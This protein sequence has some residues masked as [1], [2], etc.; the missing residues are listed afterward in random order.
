FLIII[1]FLI[2]F[3]SI[4]QIYQEVMSGKENLEQTINSIQIQNFNQAKIFAQNSSNNFSAAIN[5]VEKLKSCLL[6]R[7]SSYLKNQINDI[8]YVL[9]A[10][11]SLSRA[12]GQSASF[13]QSLKDVINNEEKSIFSKLSQQEKQ[14]ILKYLYQSGPEL[15]G[16]KANVNLALI[17]L[18][19]TNL[20]NLLYP[21]KDR[22]N[23]L[24]FQLAQAELLLDKAISI[25]E[26]LPILAGYPE[27]TKFL[28]ILENNDELRPTGGFIGTYGILEIDSG[29]I[30]EFTTHDIYHLDMP[31]KD[32]LHI[33][34]PEPLKKYLGVDYW[35]LRDANW[36][37]D[38]PT[39][40][41]KIDWFYQ[42]ENKLH[43]QASAVKDNSKE[44][45]GI[46]AITPQVII[47]LLAIV[48]PI[49]IDNVIYDKNNFQEL[50]QYK[51]EKGYVALGIPS[52]QR[53][54][55]IGDIAK[56]LK[57]RLFDLPAKQWPK[58]LTILNNNL[59]IK[60]ILVYLSDLT[61]Q[62][63]VKQ[64]GWAGEVK[65]TK[66]DYLMV[67]DANMAAL[68]TDAV[69][70]RNLEYKIN[71]NPNGLF[72]ELK[73]NYAHQGNFDWKTTRYRTYT[74]IY[75]PLNSQLIKTEGFVNNEI[76]IT[77]ELDKT[78][79]GG[80]ISIEPG[81]IGNLYLEYKLPDNL[82]KLVD[83]NYYKLYIQ[84]QPGNNVNHAIIDFNFLNKIKSFNPVSLNFQKINDNKMKWEGDLS[85]DRSF[86]VNF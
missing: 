55:V 69:I 29:D 14:S 44:F 36:S 54:E 46:I 42:A 23:E 67:V 12:A 81:K 2:N 63:F 72:A 3:F 77:N 66:D 84:K 5:N 16:L 33:I 28:V 70:N 60:N 8:E 21:L 49:E 27:K 45:A 75:A 25:T 22:I 43:D 85:I 17:Y 18:N 26:I 76:I 64:Y 61:K 51:V 9:T 41:K 38:W 83:S 37:P 39:S 50:L 59:D 57:I 32:K 10:A 31:I 47:D 53:K 73:I 78:C 6:I 86:N 20:D 24:K 11:E 79:F 15:N 30:I 62:N 80:F 34:P 1:F 19:Q 52:W 13:G 56:E 7:F 35:Y 40:A 48:G 71:Q 58:I 74:R 4:K 65:D 68:K 82:N